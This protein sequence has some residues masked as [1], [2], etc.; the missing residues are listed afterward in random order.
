MKNQIEKYE[1]AIPLSNKVKRKLWL[2]FYYIFFRPFS[3]VL[4]I[5]WRNFI[6]RLFGSSVGEGTIVYASAK[7]LAPWNL[8]IGNESCI[9]PGVKFHI[10]KTIIGAKVTI[11]QGAY[12]C[13][14]SHEVTSLNT[15]FIS[16][17]IIVKDFAWVAAECFIMMGVTIGEGAVVGARSSVFKD[18]EPW[19]IVG[20]NPA[21]FIKKRIINGKS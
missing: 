7:I 8:I 14:G 15:P 4:F 12:L 20:G 16:Q 19:S 21:K 10:D 6:L 2:F 5:K 3:G 18:V 11:S 1:D 9:G 17:P 13:S